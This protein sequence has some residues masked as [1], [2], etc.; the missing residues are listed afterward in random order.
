[1]RIEELCLSHFEFFRCTIHETNKKS[2]VLVFG[3]LIENVIWREILSFI[4][5]VDQSADIFGNC[6]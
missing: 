1:M 2:R 4:F 6:M 3:W 5:L